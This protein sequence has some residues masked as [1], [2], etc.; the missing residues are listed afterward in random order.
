[1]IPPGFNRGEAESKS[2]AL[3][4]EFW[5]KSCSEPQTPP[6]WLGTS[7]ILTVM[8]V[9]VVVLGSGLTIWSWL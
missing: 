4:A 1:M 9:G 7:L 6:W 3:E 2:L 5:E 8:L